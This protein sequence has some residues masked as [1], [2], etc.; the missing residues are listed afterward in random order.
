MRA[1]IAIAAGSGSLGSEQHCFHREAIRLRGCAYADGSIV[2][3]F[4]SYCVAVEPLSAQKGTHAGPRTYRDLHSSA[5]VR[6]FIDYLVERIGPE[7]YW[8]RL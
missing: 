3:R 8:D 4:Q 5:K 1:S 6:A 7:P 2:R